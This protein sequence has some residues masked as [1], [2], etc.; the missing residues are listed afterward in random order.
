MK[1]DNPLAA[2]TNAGGQ[3][4][5]VFKDG[6]T[7]DAPMYGK[8]SKVVRINPADSIVRKIIVGYQKGQC[9]Y[10]FKLFDA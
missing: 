5:F 4:N 1:W 10:G 8:A 7:S 6:K 3:F 2:I 9:V